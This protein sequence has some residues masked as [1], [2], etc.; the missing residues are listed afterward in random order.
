MDNPP[1]YNKPKIHVYILRLK[2]KKKKLMNK[3]ILNTQF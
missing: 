1:L 3:F 2:K